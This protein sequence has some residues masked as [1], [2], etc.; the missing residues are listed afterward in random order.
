MHRELSEIPVTGSQYISR[1]CFVCGEENHM[2]LKAQFLVLDDGRLCA[3]FEPSEEHQSYPGRLHG[4][5]TSAILDETIG[6]V[7][8][9]KHPEIF[10]VTIEL[11]VKFR[12]PVPLGCP[13]KVVATLTKESARIFEGTGELLLPDGTVAA[14][15]TA[16][17]FRLPVDAISEGGLSD[18]DWFADQR[19]CPNSIQA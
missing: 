19:Q 2:S 8:Q 12:Q 17:Y 6:R 9:V 5:V 3:T 7:V 18:E 15:A 16:R 4:G 10:G 13:L 11:N 1:M 14:Q